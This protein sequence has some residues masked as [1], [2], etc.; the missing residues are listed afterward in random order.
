MSVKTEWSDE[1][2]VRSLRKRTMRQEHPY[3]TDQVEH[4]LVRRGVKAS[5]SDLEEKLQDRMGLKSSKRPADPA[6]KKLKRQKRVLTPGSSSPEITIG[7]ITARTWLEGVTKA[8][9]P[10]NL[11]VASTSEL[12]DKMEQSWSSKLNGQSIKDCIV[13]FSWLDEGDNIFLLR[14]DDGTAFGE[15][16]K[17]ARHEAVSN[18]SRGTVNIHISA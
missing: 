8:Y 12:F 4:N 13:S 17:E 18:G 2:P 7:D 1:S 6:K 10:V 11:N 3:K 9:I 16:M 5:E 14:G 15:M